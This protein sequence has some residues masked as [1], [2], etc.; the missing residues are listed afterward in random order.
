MALSSILSIIMGFLV[1][2]IIILAIT[3]FVMSAKEKQEE[4][5]RKS[6]ENKSE[7]QENSKEKTAKSYT[8]E[9]IFNF[10]EFEKIEDN[11]I[12]QRGGKKF[13]MVIECQGIN[14]D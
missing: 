1:I 7:E 9:S 10:M 3:Y 11:M 5:S 4:F 13:L 14:Y 8:K 2:L 6:E 12:V